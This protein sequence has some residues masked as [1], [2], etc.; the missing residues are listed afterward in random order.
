LAQIFNKALIAWAHLS[1]LNILP[2]YGAF[3]EGKG[4]SISFVSPQLDERNIADHAKALLQAERMPLVC[5][6]LYIE[7]SQDSDLFP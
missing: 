7:G 5:S 3:L 4:G 6:A 1:H 2:V